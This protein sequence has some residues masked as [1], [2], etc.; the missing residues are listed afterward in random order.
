ME[1]LSIV[2]RFWKMELCTGAG[3][4]RASVELAAL[5]SHDGGPSPPMGFDVCCW[6][7]VLQ[8]SFWITE[9]KF[10]GLWARRSN[11]RAGDH[12]N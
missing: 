2:T 1:I 8:N 6:Q 4:P 3:R 9:D 5:L 7:I 10:S 12:S 11:N